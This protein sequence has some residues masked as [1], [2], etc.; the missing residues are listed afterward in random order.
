M[1]MGFVEF[2][3]F[4][5]NEKLLDKFYPLK[6]YDKPTDNKKVIEFK[7]IKDNNS[8]LGEINIKFDFIF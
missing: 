2:R 5:C 4:D 7:R 3:Y 6:E 8:Q 1:F